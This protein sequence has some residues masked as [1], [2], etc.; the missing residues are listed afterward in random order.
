MRAFSKVTQRSSA[1]VAAMA[2]V[3]MAGSTAAFAVPAGQVH[4]SLTSVTLVGA[5]CQDVPGETVKVT[6]PTVVAPIVITW[7]ME[8][9]STG[10][11]AVGIRIN[12]GGCGDYGPSYVPVP[13]NG[14]TPFWPQTIQ[15]LIFP[16][17]GLVPGKNT[18]TVCFGATTNNNQTLTLG[19]R[20]LAVRFSK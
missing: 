1:F 18:F 12:G 5:C 6:E 19:S 13:P 14:Q 11:F 2:I 16:G 9:N 20:T 10:P 3:L 17:E 4:R 7:S 15:W 8:Y